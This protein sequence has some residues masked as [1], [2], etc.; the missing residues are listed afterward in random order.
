MSGFTNK[1]LLYPLTKGDV[2]GHEF[3][4]NQYTHGSLMAHLE[5]VRSRAEGVQPF[6]VDGK[7]KS[8]RIGTDALG[9][10]H[11]VPD[12]P[13]KARQV[14]QGLTSDR[15]M[16]HT[17]EG[18][19][20]LQENGW[21]YEGGSIQRLTSRL[22]AEPNKSVEQHLAEFRQEAE[23]KTQVAAADAPLMPR[24]DWHGDRV[25]DKEGNFLPSPATPNEAKQWVRETIQEG[26]DDL[27]LA[28]YIEGKLPHQAKP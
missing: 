20:R 6:Y 21:K 14:N 15:K 18:L 27:H 5:D 19:Q 3:H 10:K 24:T 16:L 17:Y 23:R 1:E 7:L 12:A 13:E 9:T 26:K 11:S 22:E 28:D 8:P 4:G 2:L 25:F